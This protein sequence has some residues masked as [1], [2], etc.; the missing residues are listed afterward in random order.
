MMRLTFSFS[1]PN[2]VIIMPIFKASDPLNIKKVSVRDHADGGKQHMTHAHG[3]LN[4]AKQDAQNGVP[5]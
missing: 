3:P 1:P 2:N 5:P 4:L